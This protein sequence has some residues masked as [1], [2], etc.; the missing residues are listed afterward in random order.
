MERGGRRADSDL[1][2]G[3]QKRT[4]VEGTPGATAQTDSGRNIPIKGQK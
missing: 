2:E 1:G 3:C 4:G